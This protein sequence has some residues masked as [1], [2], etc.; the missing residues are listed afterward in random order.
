MASILRFAAFTA[1][2]GALACSSDGSGSD[3]DGV[4]QFQPGAGGTAPVVSPAPVTPA[5][6]PAPNGEVPAGNTEG[7]GDPPLQPANPPPAAGSG[8]GT[9]PAPPPP[10]APPPAV[11]PPAETPPAE[12]PP[13]EQ[14]PAEQP[15][16]APPPVISTDVSTLPLPPGNGAVPEPAGPPGGLEVIDWAGFRSAVSY[17]FD[18]TNQTQIDHFNELMALNV[19]FTWYFITGGDSGTRLANPIWNQAFAAGHEVANHTR[20]HL[21]AGSPNLAQDTDNGA[22]DVEQRFDTTVFTMAAPFGAADYVN[23][24]ST[25]YL[26]NRGVNG[27]QVAP[28][29]GTN[30]FSVP[31]FIPN[32]GAPASAFNTL[33][34]Q[35][36]ANG[37]WHTVLVHGFLPQ[38]NGEFQPVDIGQFTQAVNYAKAFGD[39][40][41]DTVLEVGAYWIAQRVFDAVTPTQNGADTTWTWA[42]PD[43]FPPNKFLRVRVSGGTLT[44]AGAQLPWNDRGFYEVALDKGSLTLS[45]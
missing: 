39:V 5:P 23:I 20:S 19:K 41:I 40:W 13:V 26:I 25:R 43:H 44:Q 10:V 1:I 14:P 35:G 27:G 9:P 34:D 16:A 42:L 6:S 22:A 2:I 31:T 11:E 29:D 3:D 12:E 15:P 17:T 38:I 18:D 37:T 21:N 33:V 32:Q 8:S 36:R 28:N 24:A 7:P 4:T 30:P 45:P